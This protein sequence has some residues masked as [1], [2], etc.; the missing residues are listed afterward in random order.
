MFGTNEVLVAAKQL[1]QIDGIDIADDVEEV[2]YIHFLFDQHEIVSANGAETESLCPGGQSLKSVGKAA[3]EEIYTL[4]PELRKLDN[5]PM[6][7][8]E[9]ASGR[10]GRKLAERHIRNRKDLIGG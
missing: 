10:L 2:T 9:L 5:K 3:V 1:C 7:A 6:A 4:F 8:R